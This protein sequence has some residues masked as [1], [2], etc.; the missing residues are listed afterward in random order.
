[1]LNERISVRVSIKTHRQLSQ[2]AKADKRDL[3]DY[4]RIILEA[5][6]EKHNEEAEDK[7][8]VHPQT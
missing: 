2:L 6:L 4:V 7:E 1:M 3:S 5:L 8:E